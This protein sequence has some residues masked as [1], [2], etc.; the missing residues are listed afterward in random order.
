[1]VKKTHHNPDYAKDRTA[2]VIPKGSGC[3]VP[4][5]HWQI[6]TDI[7]PEGNDSDHGAF[8]PRRGK[9]RPRPYV[10]INECDH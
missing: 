2:D 5:H 10:K 1:M 3:V 9:N 6:N 8:L 4:E 7:T